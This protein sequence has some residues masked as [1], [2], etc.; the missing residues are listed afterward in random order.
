MS[1]KL[2]TND[3]EFRLY[4]SIRSPWGPSKGE[5]NKLKQTGFDNF[6]F[7][8]NLI[9]GRIKAVSIGSRYLPFLNTNPYNECYNKKHTALYFSI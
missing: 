4:L 5:S 6:R 3:P 8:T 7:L 2:N 1:Q 9:K